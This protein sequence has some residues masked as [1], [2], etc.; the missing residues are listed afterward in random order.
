MSV[1]CRITLLFR[2]KGNSALDAAE[3]PRQ[4]L[5]Y[6]YERQLDMLRDVRRG[7]VEVTA[8]KRRLQLHARELGANADKLDNQARQALEMGRED[9]ARAA[10]ERKQMALTQVHDFDTQVAQLEGEQ[11]RLTTSEARLA[12]KIEAFHTRMEVIKAQYSAAQAQAR[13]G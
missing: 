2:A 10:L 7:I 8:S 6:S 12:A 9:L 11:E 13:I 3:D 5:D 1:M 4:T